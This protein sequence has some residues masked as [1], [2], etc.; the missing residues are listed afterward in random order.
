LAGGVTALEVVVTLT[1]DLGEAPGD[2][3][4]APV[5]FVVLPGDCAVDPALHVLA[6]QTGALAFTGAFADVLFAP[7]ELCVAV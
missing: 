3:V 5:E 1:S 2:G 4:A 6:T 7:L